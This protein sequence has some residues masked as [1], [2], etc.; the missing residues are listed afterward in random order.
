MESLHNIINILLIGVHHPRIT[1]LLSQTAMVKICKQSVKYIM[2]WSMIYYHLF[3]IQPLTFVYVIAGFY[4][5][6]NVRNRIMNWNLLSILLIL[7]YICLYPLRQ[8]VLKYIQLYT[9]ATN[10]TI[11][12]SAR[13]SSFVPNNI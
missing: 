8:C 13:E 1:L 12:K 2:T 10:T 11:V 3:Y 6:S 9:T 4:A 7:T 5:I